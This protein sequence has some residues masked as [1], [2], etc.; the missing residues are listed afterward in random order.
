TF[1]VPAGSW[2]GAEAIKVNQITDSLK[3]AGPT[4]ILIVGGLEI[5]HDP[6]FAHLLEDCTQ[7]FSFLQFSRAEDAI[8]FAPRLPFLSAEGRTS[9]IKEALKPGSTIFT[10]S[11]FNVT[12][13]GTKLD[14]CQE[15]A[16]ARLAP[17]AALSAWASIQSVVFLGLQSLP[18]KS[19][20]EKIDMQIGTDDKQLVFSLQFPI[21]REK[22]TSFRRHPILETLRSASGFFEL[23]Y[24]KAG[25]TL[26]IVS[27]FF[28]QEK[29]EWPVECH[30]FVPVTALEKN[31]SVAEYTFRQ[32]GSLR[33]REATSAAAA[34]AAP[35]APSPF[36][37][38][39][40]ERMIVAAPAEAAPETKGPVVTAAASLAPKAGS[41]PNT[42]LEMKVLSLEAKVKDR[43]V[44]IARL[45]AEITS[46]KEPGTR[47]VITNIKDTQLQGLKDN[48]ARLEDE[49][50]E[51][52]E[53]EQAK[54]S[55]EDLQPGIKDQFQRKIKDLELKLKAANDDRGSK[56]M[57]L[58]KQVEDQKKKVKDL[59]K[60]ITELTNQLRS[61]A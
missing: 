14:T 57:A 55:S 51:A 24:H 12:A 39:F 61:A 48:I 44:T 11:F 22:L 54:E 19:A 23:R 33:G 36:K 47:E 18:E 60:K 2:P 38:K 16:G 7:P 30:S 20:G 49:L 9:G 52:L 59:T 4:P 43:D 58:E 21:A 40:S 53:R 37:K 45:S 42:E 26:E 27:I 5:K 35:A 31:S 1:K 17:A 41:A 6:Q 29:P 3:K 34:A 15:L 32:L 13:I 25:S 50:A 8:R 46:L 56:I 10:E 28:A